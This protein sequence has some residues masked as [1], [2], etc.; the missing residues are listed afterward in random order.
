M[1]WDPIP[2]PQQPLTLL[3]GMRTIT[4]GGDVGSMAGSANHVYLIT[5]SMRDEYFYNADGEM[6]FVL[7]DRRAA[8]LDRVRH[9]RRDP[10]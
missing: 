2:I 10:W 4:T 5:E 3:T 6:L 8:I 7:Q 9:H 1:R